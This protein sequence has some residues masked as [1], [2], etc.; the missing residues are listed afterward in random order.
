MD[1]VVES[2]MNVV[3]SKHQV[4]PEC[5][6]Q[7]DLCRTRRPNLSREIKF[8]GANGDKENIYIFP[9]IVSLSVGKSYMGVWCFRWGRCKL[10]RCT[11][12]QII[13]KHTMILYY[14]SS[15]YF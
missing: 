13:R 8:S 3:V 6:E 2:A 4:Q 14:K 10:G 7:V 5:G 11:R 9:V 1:A 15:V 12:R